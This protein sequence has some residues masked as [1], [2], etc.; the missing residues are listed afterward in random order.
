MVRTAESNKS[1]RHMHAC[2]HINYADLNTGIDSELDYSP[3]RKKKRDIVAAL[4]EP[5]QTV[6]FAHR[7]CITRQGLR[8]MF[9]SPKHKT[10][11]LV[12]T[13]IISPPAKT[14]LSNKEIKQED[15]WLKLPKNVPTDTRSLMDPSVKFTIK[16]ADGSVC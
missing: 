5:S 1:T 15:D 16:H 10:P 11:K 8:K 9:P 2:K 4:R 12:G 13:V 6:I 7:Q 14:L 3:P